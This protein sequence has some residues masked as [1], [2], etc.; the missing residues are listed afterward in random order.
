[1]PPSSGT[2]SN[3]PLD[4]SRLTEAERAELERLLAEA[5]AT[6]AATLIQAIL[7]AP[8]KADGK[9]LHL[10]AMLLTWVLAQRPDYLAELDRVVLAGAL[11]KNS[12]LNLIRIG[13]QVGSPESRRL[14]LRWL[15]SPSL[16]EFEADVLEALNEPCMTTYKTLKQGYWN[17]LHRTMWQ[18]RSPISLHGGSSSDPDVIRASLLRLQDGHSPRVRSVAVRALSG[19]S[20]QPRRSGELDPAMEREVT[21]AFRRLLK[22][23]DD[24][25]LRSTALTYLVDTGEAVDLS[26]AWAEYDRSSDLGTRVELVPTLAWN[27]SSVADV[28]RALRAARAEERVEIRDFWFHYLGLEFAKKPEDRGAMARMIATWVVGEPEER[29]RFSALITLAELLPESADS[30]QWALSDPSEKIRAKATEALKPK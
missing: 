14:L 19:L 15:D 30:M 2:S 18:W 17:L 24:P 13:G 16:S 27:V 6:P 29:V 21:E 4:T 28:E 3:A 11:D 22:E 10:R 12:L 23:S 8:Q 1:M 9:E 20:K 26:A 7:D 25:R 5:T